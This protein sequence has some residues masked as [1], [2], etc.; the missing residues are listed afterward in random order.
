G[1]G[2]QAGRE[3]AVLVV[4]HDERG[5]VLDADGQTRHARI[6]LE[7]ERDRLIAVDSQLGA[8]EAV[9]ITE[10]EPLGFHHAGPWPGLSHQGDGDETKESSPGDP[11]PA[12]RLALAARDAPV[13]N[14][15][16]VV[17]KVMPDGHRVAAAAPEGPRYRM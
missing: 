17:S 3:L 8:D 13:S 11:A 10:H 12:A 4:Q 16:A 14:V 2:D 15:S 6:V 5:A 1:Q 9:G 7:A